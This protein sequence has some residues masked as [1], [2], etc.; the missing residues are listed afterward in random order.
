MQRTSWRFDGAHQYRNQFGVDTLCQRSPL[1]MLPSL[2][3]DEGDE[4]QKAM[5][6][7]DNMLKR[8]QRRRPSKITGRHLFIKDTIK[9]R[10]G[11]A[12]VSEPSAS[13]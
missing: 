11:Q 7:F 5:A 13:A 9:L 6:L 4:V 10:K 3:T 12:H 1:R 8:L 2:L